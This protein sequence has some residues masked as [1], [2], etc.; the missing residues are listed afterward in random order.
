MTDQMEA[1]PVQV[2]QALASGNAV[3]VDVREP[4]E[5]EQKR[6]AGSI[7]IPLAEVPNR[8]N[9]I[10]ADR[11]VYVHCRLGGRSSKAVEFLRQSG[12]PRAANLTGGIEAWEEAGLPVE[13]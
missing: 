6:I 1:S 10:P 5:W 7:L 11:E 3:L 4:W 8:L 9:E 13:G 2:S 12:R